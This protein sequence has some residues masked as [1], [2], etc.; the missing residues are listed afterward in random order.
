MTSPD[1]DHAQREAALALWRY[2]HDYLR[3]AQTLCR[4]HR[5]G[6]VDSQVPYHLVAQ[7]IEFAL[8]AYLRAKGASMT[9]LRAELG[10]SLTRALEQCEAKGMPP[11]RAGDRDAIE[12]LSIC[13]RDTQF[14]H[15]ATA[16]DAFPNIDPL[17]DV[18]VWI[19]DW[20]APD[21]VEHYVVRGALADATPPPPAD[22]LC[23]ACASNCVSRRMCF[24]G[25]HRG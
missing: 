2:A 16:E 1:H 17:V 22:F 13:H 6:C 24:H 18:G 15:L 8:K 11:L 14:V 25:K 9:A 5:I 12:E 3:A 21:V 19:L 10:H 23:A 20:I 4:Q 7:G